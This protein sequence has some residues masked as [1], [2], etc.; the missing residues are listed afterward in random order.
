MRKRLVPC[1]AGRAVTDVPPG[2]TLDS[3]S[4]VYIGGK[5]TMTYVF[6]VV[7]QLNAEIGAHLA[8]DIQGAFVLRVPLQQLF[9]GQ[10]IFCE[11]PQRFQT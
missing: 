2:G 6:Q 1:S 11:V 5:P 8:H 3:G 4:V 7:A 9:I 10:R